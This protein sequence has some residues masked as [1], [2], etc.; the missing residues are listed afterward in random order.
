MKDYHEPFEEIKKLVEKQNYTEAADRME[1]FMAEVE[2]AYKEQKGDA[3][4]FNHILE[5]YQYEYFKKPQT[6]PV[7]TDLNISAFY[8][9]YGF[10]LMHLH[11]FMD[12]IEAYENALS[13][14]PVDLD[15][16]LQLVELYKRTKQ[17]EKVKEYSFLCY[18]LC[19]TRATLAH[20]YRG[21][22]FYYLEKQKPDIAI[23]LYI[24]SNIY[25]E[26]KQ[27]NHELDYLEKA[28]N[29]PIKKYT[30]PQL[31]EILKAN[32]IPIGPNADTI[33]IAYR[34][35]QLELETGN[36]E[37]ARDCFTMVYD[38][39]MDLEVKEILEKL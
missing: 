3:F 2:H 9:F 29:Q 19:C 14:N 34:V 31:Q 11:L 36:M 1:L 26:T 28:L 18:D 5:V 23:P 13:W 25:Y 6:S 24:Y 30:I 20:F 37:N 27:A 32:Q 16:L 35:G 33:G 12:A 22:G 8:R 4:S 15:A 39:T 10:V 21:L 38:L 7:Y 17:P